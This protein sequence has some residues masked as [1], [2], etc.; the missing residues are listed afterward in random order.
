MAKKFKTDAQ[1]DAELGAVRGRTDSA[2]SRTESGIITAVQKAQQIELDR[3]LE[4]YDPSKVVDPEKAAIA[5]ETTKL[6]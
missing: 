5:A 2:A 4:G 3:A 6:K 1:K